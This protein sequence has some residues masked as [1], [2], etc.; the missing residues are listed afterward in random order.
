MGDRALL[1][2]NSVGK[3]EASPGVASRMASFENSIAQMLWPD[4]RAK[5]PVLG[6]KVPGVIDRTTATSWLRI[7]TGYLPDALR[8]SQ[9]L[10][11]LIVP[12]FDEKGIEIGPIPKGTP[13]DLLANFDPLP[14]SPG[15]SARVEHD[16][17]VVAAVFKLVRDLRALPKGATDDQA[18]KVFANVGEQ[19]FALSKCPDYVVNRGHYFGSK[20]ERCRQERADRLPE[21][22]LGARR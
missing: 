22:V 2:N 16:K 13:V 1:L 12:V 18:R 19:L 11:N 5:D 10:L 17:Q 4:K 9:R 7:P 3:F 8:H 15:L 14:P 21:D 6:D 20:L